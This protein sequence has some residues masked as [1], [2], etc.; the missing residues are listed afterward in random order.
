MNCLLFK[1]NQT[2]NRVGTIRLTFFKNRQTGV[3]F[4]V[5]RVAPKAPQHYLSLGAVSQV[6]RP[7]LAR[8]DKEGY[9]GDGPG[10]FA[11]YGHSPTREL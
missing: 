9:D 10:N 1:A 3:V 8:E 4:R 5:K 6:C 11:G 2:L 7:G